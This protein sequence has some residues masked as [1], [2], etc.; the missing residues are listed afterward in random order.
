MNAGDLGLLMETACE[1]GNMMLAEK[2]A[3]PVE[4]MCDDNGE[5][6]DA[7]QE[8]FDRLYDRI[9]DILIAL[10]GRLHQDEPDTRSDDK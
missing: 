10:Y 6:T 8:E 3:I 2:H 1:L 5:F 4:D 7:Y 9:E